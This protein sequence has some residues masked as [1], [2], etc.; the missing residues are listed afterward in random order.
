MWNSD[1]DAQGVCLR[2]VKKG[3]AL[4]PIAG[5]DERAVIDV[6]RGYNSGKWRSNFLKPL[7]LFQPGHVRLGGS[8]IGLARIQGGFP[9]IKLL[10]GDDFLFDQFLPPLQCR[11]RQFGVRRGLLRS[12]AR[13]IQFL[14]DFR[15]LD[16]RQQLA[17]FDFRTDIG[18]PL[19]DVAVGPRIHRRL[20]DCLCASGQNEVGS[21]V[22]ALRRHDTYRRALIAHRT[23]QCSVRV[24]TWEHSDKKQQSEHHERAEHS[25][26]AQA[27]PDIPR[28]GLKVS[29]ERFDVFGCG[30]LILS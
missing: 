29:F 3:G 8:E 22:G 5:G 11:A 1:I 27:A 18:V 24:P 2:H 14:I 4:A 15:C 12:G 26:P 10:R 21:A 6:A 20:L 28:G 19:A 23:R 30:H 25:A 17:G 16:F 7:Q 13:L 9:L